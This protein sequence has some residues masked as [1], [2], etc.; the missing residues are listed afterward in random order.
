M[1]FA[2]AKEQLE[3]IKRGTVEIIPEAELLEKLEHSRKTGKPLNIKLGCDP[4][5][6]IFTSATLLC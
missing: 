2:P 5:V 3:I 4:P 1:T 6:P